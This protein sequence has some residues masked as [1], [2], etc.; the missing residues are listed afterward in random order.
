MYSRIPRHNV[1]EFYPGFYG[2][3]NK[4]NYLSMV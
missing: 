1:I 2:F 3:F 4:H